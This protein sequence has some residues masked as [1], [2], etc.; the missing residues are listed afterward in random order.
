MPEQ[1]PPRDVGDTAF[2]DPD[3]SRLQPY[4]IDYLERV[5]RRPDMLRVDEVSYGLMH[6]RP[7]MRVLEIGPGLGADAAEMA[8]RVAPRGHVLG[9]DRSEDF[10]RLARER[11]AQMGLPLEFRTGD[12]HKLELP[13]ESF[14]AVR[15]ERSMQYSPDPAGVVAELVRVLAPGGWLV[16]AE[17]DWGSMAAEVGDEELAEEATRA[18]LDM[19]RRSG[20]SPRLGI[21]LPG[22]LTSAGLV[23]VEAVPVSIVERTVDGAGEVMPLFARS[24]P[25]DLAD[26][27]D[28]MPRADEWRA[29]LDDADARGTFTAAL[30]M[31]VVGGRKPD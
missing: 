27:L 19:L 12:M 21:Q 14:D 8:R 10:V 20:F 2:D 28:V 18:F 13:D 16:A 24:L 17:P 15:V 22:L 26:L 9:I 31:W 11:T 1:P 4:L 7:G 23:D 3:R 30:Q 29:A 6:L 5:G 25:P